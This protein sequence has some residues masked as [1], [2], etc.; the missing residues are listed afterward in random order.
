M[1]TTLFIN[2]LLLAT[3]IFV[4]VSLLFLVAQYKANNSIMD[5]AYGPIFFLAMLG[6]MYISG[7][8]T[9]TS[10]LMLIVVGLWSSRLSFRIARKN[11][12]KPEDA[13]Y[14][15]WRTKWM[16]V[17]ETYFLKRSYF[18]IFLL[19][20]SVIAL[21][22]LP[23]VVALSGGDSI[24]TWPTILGLCLSLCGL[25]YET[26]A[27]WQL[28]RFLK[29]KQAGTEQAPIMTTGL[30]RYSRRPNY[31]GEAL[32]WWGLALMAWPFAY[33]YIAFVS[34]LLI[35]YIVTR[36]TGP[37]LENIFLEKYSEAYRAYMKTANYFIP[38]KPRA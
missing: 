8:A 17:S 29:R 36:V 6:T 14:A 18:Q 15:A 35:T 2:M 25:A 26:T 30:F 3:C 16:R 11:Y 7:T 33:S 19:Q 24:P 28:D 12:G 38:W 23:F 1:L 5:I 13:R 21:V 9:R 37:M 27:D 31:F 4:L 22:S 34:P 10:I 32:I 20:G